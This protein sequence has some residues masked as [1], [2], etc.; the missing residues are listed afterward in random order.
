MKTIDKTTA[1][2]NRKRIAQILAIAIL[3]ILWTGLRAEEFTKIYEGKYD[4]D[5]GAIMTIQ[6]KFGKV[7]CQVWDESSVSVK[8]TV[9]VEASSQDTAEKVFDK[10]SV[11]LKGNRSDVSGISKVGNI[12][13]AEY[14]IDYDIRMPRW[15]NI[16]IDNKFGDVFL[17]EMDGTVK[18]NLEY[19]ALE[20]FNL[21][22]NTNV[23]TIKFGKA[24]T[25]F[26]KDGRINIEYSDLKTAG[27]GN[28]EIVSRFSELTLEKTG[29]LKLDSQYDNVKAESLD[30]I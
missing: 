22:S 11:E 24:K 4:V 9:T 2:R 3:T 13:E 6:N 17:D 1:K 23:L 27:A 12:S 19:G 14:S 15:I 28:L 5:K 29:N 7:N 30:G 20:A 21:N 26:I 16:D 10:I 25:G 18:L 8:V